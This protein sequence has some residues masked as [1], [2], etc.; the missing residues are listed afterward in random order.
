MSPTLR[1]RGARG[2][3]IPFVQFQPQKAK[4]NFL[5][6]IPVTP[7]PQFHLQ[8]G[9]AGHFGTLSSHV[10]GVR[11]AGAPIICAMVETPFCS[12]RVGYGVT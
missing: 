9:D 7:L 5:N 1:G 10:C 3:T 4:W 12:G 11:R 6:G 8:G 2:Q